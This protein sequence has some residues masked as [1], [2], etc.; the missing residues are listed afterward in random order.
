MEADEEEQE[1]VGGRAE[2]TERLLLEETEKNKQT[3]P[4]ERNKRKHTDTKNDAEQRGKY[5]QQPTKGEKEEEEK[6][7]DQR[8]RS[9]SRDRGRQKE[10]EEAMPHIRE[11][12]KQ[13]TIWETMTNPNRITR[14]HEIRTE[15][16][17]SNKENYTQGLHNPSRKGREEEGQKKKKTQR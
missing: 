1:R 10:R 7:M 8:L 16:G 6:A 2:Q 15:P 4:P 13:K 17:N 3:E 9:E 14:Q 12:N 5:L 11:M